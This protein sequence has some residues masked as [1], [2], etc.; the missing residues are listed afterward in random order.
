MSCIACESF[1][2]R[3]A[4][5]HRDDDLKIKFTELTGL[6]VIGWETEKLRFVYVCLQLFSLQIFEDTFLCDDCNDKLESSYMFRQQ[7]IEVFTRLRPDQDPRSFEE[8]EIQEEFQETQSES[9]QKVIFVIEENADNIEEEENKQFSEEKGE[10]N[11]FEETNEDFDYLEFETEEEIELKMPRSETTPANRKSYTV[12]EKLN[13]IKFAEENNNRTAARHFSI[14]ESS[15]RCFRRQK[16]MLLT[17]NPQKKT[18][19]KANPHWPKLEEELK[20]FVL[21]NGSSPKL[22]EIKQKAIEIAERNGIEKFSGSNSYI[23]KFM[24]RHS[25]PAFSP[26]PRKIKAETGKK[27]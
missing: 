22:R 16:Q 10:E 15:V 4:N 6:Q 5:I 2:K 23:F 14:N 3:L 19:R 27:S 8:E 25:L 20:S 18:N 11:Q 24:Q 7:C 13:I 26:R 9:D 1:P 17:M 12:E 21:G